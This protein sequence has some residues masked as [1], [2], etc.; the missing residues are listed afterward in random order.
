MA[1]LQVGKVGPCPRS[2]VKLHLK[3]NRLAG[4]GSTV[5]TCK[6]APVAQTF[7]VSEV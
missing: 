7:V 5:P 4:T 6:F 1:N 3:V 2:F